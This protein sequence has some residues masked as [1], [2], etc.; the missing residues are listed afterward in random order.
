MAGLVSVPL[1]PPAEPDLD[2]AVT[3]RGGRT[4][5]GRPLADLDEIEEVLALLAP[6]DVVDISRPGVCVAQLEVGA[7]DSVEVSL[8]PI[9]GPPVRE[10]VRA[11]DLRAT[12]E[13]AVAWLQAQP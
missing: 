3:P 1:A 7:A 6:G 10:L 8:V 12:L 11:S 9:V 13:R 2:W 5:P 4:E